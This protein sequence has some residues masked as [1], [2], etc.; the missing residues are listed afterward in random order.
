MNNIYLKVYSYN[1]PAI[2]CY[3]KIGF[4]EAGKLREAKIIAGIKYDE[5]YM[6]ILAKEFK[7]LYVLPI[8]LTKLNS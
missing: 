1:K 4:K 2:N 6:D 3:K 7:S 5:I 8:L